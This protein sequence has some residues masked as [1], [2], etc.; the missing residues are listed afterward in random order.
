VRTS[1]A[2]FVGILG[3][4]VGHPLPGQVSNQSSGRDL[5]SVELIR[6]DCAN[7]RGSVETV[8]F[9]NGTV[10]VRTGASED[11]SL[12]E[13]TLEEVEIYV[14]RLEEYDLREVE[15]RYR[16]GIVGDGVDV[17]EL[18]LDLDGDGGSLPI[19]FTVSPYDAYAAPLGSVLD[20]V[21]ELGGKVSPASTAR[22][23]RN[24][25]ARLGDI[26]RAAD[27]LMELKFRPKNRDSVRT[28]APQPAAD[29]LCKS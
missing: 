16:R 12:G 9:A 11:I 28:R 8:L 1:I 6:F 19:Y 22:L 4:W 10:R 24:Y 20:I 13:M 15:T 18:V 7:T 21:S 2:V 3:L 25:E 23:P 5:R 29:D 26:L 27:V 14:D 17:C